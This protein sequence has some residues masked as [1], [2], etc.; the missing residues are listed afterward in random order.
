MI[1][2]R[3]ILTPDN[4]I[5]LEKTELEEMTGSFTDALLKDKVE[6]FAFLSP[7]LNLGDQGEV[8]RVA[9]RVDSNPVSIIRL[10]CFNFH[11]EWATTGED[12][13]I[14]PTFDPSSEGDAINPV[15][16]APD[17]LWEIPND[18][19]HYLVYF[20]E[21]S[22]FMYGYPNPKKY[23][24]V[25]I[26]DSRAYRLPVPNVFENGRLCYDLP[27]DQQGQ[28]LPVAELQRYYRNW[29]NSKWNRDLYRSNFKA[30]FK[31]EADTGKQ[32][33]WNQEEGQHFEE[34]F[35][36]IRITEDA[37]WVHKLLW[38][39]LLNGEGA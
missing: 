39:N 30:L 16:Q 12:N 1:N 28:S 35:E 19:P 32:L 26:S 9:C 7:M 5:Y 2:E 37:A 6:D 4:K 10:K 29:L 11:T 34:L 20:N 14:R 13:I 21:H 17:L 33:P 27:R 31:W 15:E 22:V 25:S 23:P 3:F 24:N 36:P 18:F 8:I 38:N